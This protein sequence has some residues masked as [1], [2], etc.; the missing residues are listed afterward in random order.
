MCVYGNVHRYVYRQVCR[1]VYAQ[2]YRQMYENVYRRVYR[3]AH[4]SRRYAPCI[5]STR[6][7][8]LRPALFRPILRPNTHVDMRLAHRAL[9]RLQELVF[10]VFFNGLKRVFS[11]QAAQTALENR[12]LKQC[13]RKTKK[14]AQREV[15]MRGALTEVWPKK[16]SCLF[17]KVHLWQATLSG[18]ACRA[19]PY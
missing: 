2:V 9:L 13:P 6:P 11:R 7:T 4:S 15:F 18:S 1:H 16:K 12:F 8:L 10:A 3:R 14:G 19:V 5:S 17:K